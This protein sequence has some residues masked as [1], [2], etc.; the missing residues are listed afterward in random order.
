MFC[1]RSELHGSLYSCWVIG[2]WC[3]NFYWMDEWVGASRKQGKK[4]E[5][6]HKFL[7]P[8]KDIGNAKQENPWKLDCLSMPYQRIEEPVALHQIQ[9]TIE[10]LFKAMKVT[11]CI[12]KLDCQRQIMSLHPPKTKTAFRKDI[13]W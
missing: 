4:G 2:H 9:Y 1:A 7:F 11:R 6:E 12:A 8:Q 10:H 13:F 3:Q 5:T